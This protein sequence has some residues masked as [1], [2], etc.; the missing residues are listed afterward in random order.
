LR[1]EPDVIRLFHSR[2]VAPDR[3]AVSLG[4]FHISRSRTGGD[5]AMAEPRS[6][7]RREPPDSRPARPLQSSSRAVRWG[8]RPTATWSARVSSCSTTTTKV[9]VGPAICWAK[10]T[11]GTG[12][13]GRRD[14]DDG[15]R[16]Q[17][18]SARSSGRRD[19]VFS[20]DATGRVV[21]PGLHQPA[22][23]RG[24]R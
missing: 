7:I 19:P 10:R 8:S 5:R 1:D 22:V 21:L 16:R 2:P 11:L 24:A 18:I 9:S 20:F 17:Q 12:S 3:T 13:P 4:D 23:R 14:T 6:A 15:E